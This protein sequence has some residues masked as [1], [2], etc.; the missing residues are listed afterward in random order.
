M[1]EL[2]VELVVNPNTVVRAYN[3]LEHEGLLRIERGKGTF[4]ADGEPLMR[5]TERF[6]RL[7]SMMDRVLVEA[8]HL[9]IPPRQVEKAWNGRFQNWRERLAAKEGEGGA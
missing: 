9:K 5:D 2:A 7:E 1:R 8:Y 3:E 6:R 4:V